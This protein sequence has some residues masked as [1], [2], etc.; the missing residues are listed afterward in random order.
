MKYTPLKNIADVLSGF[1]FKSEHFRESGIPVIR[2]GDI[3][4]D[5]TIAID[6]CKCVDPKL[7]S[8]QIQK[9]YQVLPN[10]ILMALSGATTGKIGI[11]HDSISPALL[12][13]RVAIIRSSNSDT[14]N[15]LKYIF[16][17]KLKQELLQHALGAAQANLSPKTL[18]S[19]KIPLPPIA[20]QK[21]IAAIL[22]KA[23]A[24]RR[25]RR[26]A[27]RLTEELLRSV[28]LDMFGD[29]GKNYRGWEVVQLQSACK[30]ITD[31]THHMPGTLDFGIPILRALNIRQDRLDKSD[32]VYVSREDF[33]SISKRSKIEKGDVLLT[34]LG[35]I[36]KSTIFEEDEEYTLVR[37][38]SLIKTKSSKIIP[39]FLTGLLQSPYMQ[40]QMKARSRASTQPALYLSE[41]AKLKIILPPIDLQLKYLQTFK[42]LRVRVRKLENQLQES[43]DLFDSLLQHA[44]TGN[45]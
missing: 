35:S 34:C 20:E 3:Q 9:K 6:S 17:E 14:Q 15:Y 27:I 28:F 29:P 11:A 25:K 18:E 24:V 12:N 37:N 22:D 21:R 39:E 1:A 40:A 42:L 10:D 13:Q 7:T 45:L 26:E 33:N 30:K 16:S 5:Q 19:L 41:I 43:E 2:I 38:I 36:G 8:S 23:D 32:L 31:G 44:F 4:A